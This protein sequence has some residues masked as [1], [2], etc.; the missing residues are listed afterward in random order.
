MEDDQEEQDNGLPTEQGG[1]GGSNLASRAGDA[2]QRKLGDKLKKD[3]AKKAAV[4]GKL[5]AALGPVIFWTSVVIVAIIIIIGIIMFFETMP[6]VIMDRLKAIGKKLVEGIANYWGGDSGKMIDPEEIYSALDYIDQ[7]HYD[8]KGYGFLT[9]YY[10]SNEK[11][12]RSGWKSIDSIIDSDYD[13]IHGVNEVPEHKLKDGV[14]RK[15]ED[16]SVLLA[17]SDFIIAYMVSDN[18]LYT[19][20]NANLATGFWDA[21]GQRLKYWVGFSLDK[22]F[23]KGMIGIYEE[24]DRVGIGVNNL[25]NYGG[26]NTDDV[27]INPSTKKLKIKKGNGLFGDAVT[28]EYDL[29]GWSGRYGMPIDFLTSVHVATMMPDLAYDMQDRFDTEV[30]VVL[31]D[32]TVTYDYYYKTES[33]NYASEDDLIS[34][35]YL[36]RDVVL[37]FITGESTSG[38]IS[39]TDT[40]ADVLGRYD[41]YADYVPLKPALDSA[42]DKLEM[43]YES[44]DVF[45]SIDNLID[46][47]SEIEGILGAIGNLPRSES[48]YVPYIEKVTK[49]WYRDVYYSIFK[50][51][52]SH[53][54]PNIRLVNYD[55]DY[56]K[57]YNERWTLYETYDDTGE[58]KLYALNSEGKYA[59]STSE[60][61]NYSDE[62]FEEENGY[63]LF[64]GSEE[65]QRAALRGEDENATRYNIAKM[66]K[67]MK[68]TG[69]EG[70]ETFQDVGWNDHGDYWSAYKIK[71]N[72]RVSSHKLAD[73]AHSI[74]YTA[75][76]NDALIQT[77][78]GQ[79][80]ETNPDIKKM[81]LSNTYFRYDGNT[82]NAE[83]I[84]ALRKK[85]INYQ[86]GGH[87]IKN[88]Y[89]YGALNELGNYKMDVTNLKYSSREEDLSDLTRI[90][91][92]EYEDIQN[93]KAE[94]LDQDI[95]LYANSDYSGQVTLNQDSLNAFSMLENT[96]TLDSDYIYR[97]F[98]ELVV[99]LGYFTKQ[100][101]T[102]ETPRLLEFL[103]PEVGSANYPNRKIDKRE[104]EYGTMIHS[105]G[106]IKAL[107]KNENDDERGNGDG[108]EDGEH[109]DH[110]VP[111]G[112]PT[113]EGYVPPEVEEEPVTPPADP[114][115]PVDP[116][117]EDEGE[118]DEP[119]VGEEFSSDGRTLRFRDDGT[120]EIITP[121][122]T[123]T[124]G[125][126][127]WYLG[128]YYVISSDLTTATP[129]EAVENSEVSSLRRN[130]NTALGANSS[131]TQSV[132][133]TSSFE[134]N[135]SITAEE[136]LE[137]ADQV[138][139]NMENSTWSYCYG[140]P[141]HSEGNLYHSVHTVY[142]TQAASLAATHTV[143]CSSY[144]CWVLQAAEIV[145]TGWATNA[146]GIKATPQFE[147]YIIDRSDVTEVLPGDI[148][149]KMGDGTS[150]SSHTQING[151]DNLQYNCGSTNAIRKR[152]YKD[153]SFIT[154][155]PTGHGYTH[156]LRLFDHVDKKEAQE[157]K[158]YKGNDAVVSPVTG[159]LLEYGCYDNENEANKKIDSITNEAYRVNVDLKYGPPN[160]E[161]KNYVK[162]IISDSVGYAKILVLDQENYQKLEAKLLSENKL[163][164]AFKQDFSNSNFSDET[165]LNENGT[166]RDFKFFSDMEAKNISKRTG[167]DWNEYDRTLYGYKEFAES[168]EK[169]G[170]AGYII[171]ID[172]FLPELPDPDFSQEKIK[173]K[174]PYEGHEDKRRKN[175]YTTQSVSGGNGI[176]FRSTTLDNLTNND[177]TKLESKY[178]TDDKYKLMTKSETNKSN[179][180]IKLKNKASSSLYVENIDSDG[181]DLIF[182][183]EGTIIGRTM[184][185][186]ELMTESRKIRTTKMK[187]ITTAD[188]EAAE[189]AET[190][191][192]P[193]HY[194][195]V[196]FEIARKKSTEDGGVPL[197][198]GNYL[199]IIMRDKD[200]T[201]VEDVEDYM[202]L[203]KK[204]DT[205]SSLEK[206][207]MW[208]ALEPEGFHYY[209]TKEDGTKEGH[210][211]EQAG[212]TC[213]R[214]NSSDKYGYD[215]VICNGGA[216]DPNLCPG[217]FMGWS[218]DSLN[219]GGQKVQEVCGYSSEKIVSRDYNTWVT[220]SQ[221]L[222]IYTAEL[223]HEVDTIRRQ[224][225]KVG[226]EKLGITVDGNTIIEKLNQD[227]IN[228]LID[229]VYKGQGYMS[230]SVQLKKPSPYTCEAT[231]LKKLALGKIDQVDLYDFYDTNRGHPRRR[232]ADYYMYKEGIYL[233]HVNNCSYAERFT[234]EKMKDWSERYDF[235]S[236]TPFQDLMRGIK[237]ANLTSDDIPE[238]TLQE[239]K[240]PTNPVN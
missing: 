218:A 137:I 209:I 208:Q 118:P 212:N 163:S 44:A 145:P 55:S 57:L 197:V 115:D 127:F 157:Y 158:G 23:T 190:E 22:K 186:K 193:S 12:Y 97:D 61:E 92:Q 156:I 147:Q 76:S 214:A 198:L 7:M 81:F 40:I 240:H 223:E 80:R 110:D 134:L 185:D 139:S 234:E 133:G 162:Q 60:I 207:M 27:E 111:P 175:T 148:L 89:Q 71:D 28:Y 58:F 114:V 78:E 17:K 124:E 125:T 152:P 43:T 107:E 135:I 130:P 132:G 14:I 15:T 167:E 120:L 1:N 200:T 122:P 10:T 75:S 176:S 88:G 33:G 217:I 171:Y 170:I 169:G 117:P 196:T 143:D 160:K 32:Y 66:A 95:N 9:D 4:K 164:D 30:K 101:L 69:E 235:L 37:P 112:D 128:V 65:E 25:Y 239:L 48:Y 85:L 189:A 6:G 151:E 52:S 72:P 59:T 194:Q 86:E 141:N 31:H 126:T 38:D 201:P 103:T 187:Y 2:A 237:P 205:S 109:E 231:L 54:D 91:D 108:R 131:R 21:L 154:N 42:L 87:K 16:N 82:K 221:L 90:S 36:L 220:G 100:E 47:L 64:K 153:T 77:G 73:S 20:R 206:L 224:I 5:A 34:A 26:L 11:D 113:V 102:D 94:G 184:T 213:I 211:I 225:E 46:R 63:Y 129:Q 155:P 51:S 228:G 177:R 29:D 199:R 232:V 99:E 35:R 203:D 84:T 226:K 50:D 3:A 70:T 68:T 216:N 136:F 74:W 165:L 83:I 18:Y 146:N 140:N 161:Q 39:E 8:L 229:V 236:E 180:E 53:A 106:D 93:R 238:Y 121:L 179:A 149:L 119:E 45:D 168:Y 172:G 123:D 105:F 19:L 178:I 192:D 222:E 219:F 191:V 56:E 104:N 96:H 166:Y 116:E 182:L 230:G 181:N 204:D 183:K 233:A 173:E 159:V 188:A 49:H 98:K 144:V 41:G 195:D 174:I 210:N 202:K 67:T 13:S 227:Q 24:S 215:W 62:L 142:S 150:G 138:H 79:R